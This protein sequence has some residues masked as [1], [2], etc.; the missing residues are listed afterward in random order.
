MG[1][2]LQGSEAAAADGSEEA[3][4]YESNDSDESDEDEPAAGVAT[5][6]GH[7]AAPVRD[8]G[9]VGWEDPDSA[10]APMAAAA[11]VQGKSV[12]VAWEACHTTV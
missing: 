5:G 2:L 3:Q 4:A 7:S 11:P 8:L 12:G 10:A 6:A 1:A 9:P